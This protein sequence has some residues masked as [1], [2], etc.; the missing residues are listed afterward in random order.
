VIVESEGSVEQASA[1]IL[2]SVGSSPQP[3]LRVCRFLPEGSSVVP[4]QTE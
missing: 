1:A 3:A 2:A 4:G